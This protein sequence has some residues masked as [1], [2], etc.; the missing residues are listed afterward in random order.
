MNRFR[1]AP[2]V[3][4]SLILPSLTA[5]AALFSD[6]QDGHTYQAEIEALARA[7]IVTGN[8]DGTFAPGR[9]VNRAEMLAM[10]YRAEGLT[11]GSSRNCF[12]DV[13]AGSWYE[14]YVCDAVSRNFVRGDPNGWFRPG[15]PVN[16]AEAL[17]MVIEVLGLTQTDASLQAITYVDAPL[18]AWFGLYV[19]AAVVAEVLPIE[20]Q[21]GAFLHPDWPLLRGEAAAYIHNAL[22][23]PLYGTSSSSSLKDEDDDQDEDKSSFSSSQSSFARRSSSSLA[24]ALGTPQLS[25][26]IPFVGGGAFTEKRP[27][28]FTF[29]ATST[30]TVDIF[31]KI[32]SNAGGMSCRLYRIEAD[33]FSYQY[34][35]GFEYGQRCHMRATI[36][37]GDYQLQLQPLFAN[38]LF[39][40]EIGKTTGD[41]ND[42]F[43]EAKSLTKNV[44][45]TGTL[46][47]NDYEDFYTFTIN[48][49]TTLTVVT[50]GSEDTSCVVYVPRSVDL[51]GFIGPVCNQPY[52]YPAGKYHISVGRTVEPAATQT[53]TIRLQ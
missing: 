10:L 13:A 6:V 33:G 51:F 40:V 29:S 28:A 25:V 3:A 42:G 38:A 39:S 16:R 17:K 41:G 43:S 20:G 9:S 11:P 21:N 15:D 53:Y 52:E 31:A 22:Y 27:S 5:Y 23:G 12:P 19:R 7:G 50:G 47:G 32:T 4:V 26:S 44:M 24:S 48:T 35:L 46:T 18:S 49:K 36:T 30:S 45:K 2:F 1:L 37:R 14:S 34:H 8:P